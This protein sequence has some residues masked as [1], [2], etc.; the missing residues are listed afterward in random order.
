MRNPTDAVLGGCIVIT[1]LWVWSKKPRDI[2]WIKHLVGMSL[3]VAGPV[4]VAVVVGILTWQV[5]LHP[6]L[7]A[8]VAEAERSVNDKVTA[9]VDETKRSALSWIPWVGGRQ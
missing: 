4:A 8:K 1:C 9:K 2:S 6:F 3:A 7:D 5:W